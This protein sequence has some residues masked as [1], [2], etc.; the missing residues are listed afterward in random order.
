MQIGGGWNVWR[1]FSY[2]FAFQDATG[3]NFVPWTLEIDSKAMRKISPN[4]NMVLVAES[5]QGAYSISTPLR[6]LVKLS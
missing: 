6:V 5:Q 1:S 3:V 2:R 4:E